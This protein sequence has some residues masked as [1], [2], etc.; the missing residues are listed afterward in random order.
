MVTLEAV[1]AQF[2]TMLL[3]EKTNRQTGYTVYDHI[4]LLLLLNL[5]DGIILLLR[6]VQLV[7]FYVAFI[8]YSFSP[9]PTKWAMVPSLA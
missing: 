6:D 8:Q 4:L 9:L 3:G 5:Q 7:F 2:Q 1:L